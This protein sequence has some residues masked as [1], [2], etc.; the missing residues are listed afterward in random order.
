[1][2]AVANGSELD[3]SAHLSGRARNVFFANNNIVTAG[4][5]NSWGFRISGGENV[6]IVDNSVRVSFHKL[7]RMND[8]PVD[9][10]YIKGGIWMREATQT[11]GGAL[12]N[13]SFAQISGSTTD[14]VHIEDPTVYLLADAPVSFGASI[15]PAQ[16]GR[17][18]HARGI[19]WHAR[20]PGVISAAR[21]QQLEDLCVNI[22]GLCDYDAAG[23]SYNVDASVQFP[24]DPWRDLPGFP[25]DD[26][27]ALPIQP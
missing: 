8:D 27:D 22:G 14:N 24:P 5:R 23:H 21:M 12:L 9:Y 19:T 2:V 7:V 10:V 3:G 26:P 1:M 15:E 17:R 4:N 13:D 16:S 25:D 20:N 18:W 11:S 6:L